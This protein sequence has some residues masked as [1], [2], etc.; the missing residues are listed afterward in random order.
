MFSQVPNIKT[1]DLSNFDLSLV[2]DMGSFFENCGQVEFINF[3]NGD[4]RNVENMD[5]MFSNDME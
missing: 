5:W 1:I 4:A 3:R 2:T